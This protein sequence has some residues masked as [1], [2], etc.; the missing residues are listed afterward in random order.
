VPDS[1]RIMTTP[2]GNPAGPTNSAHNKI[3]IKYNK[4]LRPKYMYFSMI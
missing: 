1:N 3:K 4:Y 2:I